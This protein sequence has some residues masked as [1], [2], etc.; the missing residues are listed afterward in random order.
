MF[1]FEVP[2]E[3]VQL[4]KDTVKALESSN[5]NTEVRIETWHAT[6]KKMEVRD[7]LQLLKIQSIFTYSYDFRTNDRII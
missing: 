4:V 5:L 3:V 7:Q 1:Q 2:G 6:L